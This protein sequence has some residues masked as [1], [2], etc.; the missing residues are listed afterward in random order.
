MNS[1]FVDLLKLLE[2]FEVEYV[3]V[4]G[5]AVM[6]YTEPRSTKDIDIL[7]RR[8]KG[9]SQ[10][11]YDALKKFGASLGGIENTFF[12]T[13]GKF[14]KIGRP[15]NRIDIITSVEGVAEQEIFENKISRELGSGLSIWFIDKAHLLA[16]KEAAGRPQDLID[17]EK[18]KQF[19]PDLD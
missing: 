10:K 14:Y 4:G 6:E 5:Y 3:I 9:N 15:P 13:E 1:D 12:E 2:S 17:A 19:N 8:S 11:I 18:L 7:V 16:V